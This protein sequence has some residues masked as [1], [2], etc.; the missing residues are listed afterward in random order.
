M[1]KSNPFQNVHSTVL[2][3]IVLLRIVLGMRLV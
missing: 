1:S 2:N 3:S